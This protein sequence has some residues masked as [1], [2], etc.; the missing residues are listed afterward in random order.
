MVKKLPS[1]LISPSSCSSSL[2]MH[3]TKVDFPDPEGPHI[4][5][6]CPR[7]TLRLTL[8]SALNFPKYLETLQISM[9]S[10]IYD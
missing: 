8:S 9:T 6:F 4:T 10:F 2:F 5:T 7:I 1:T 3:L